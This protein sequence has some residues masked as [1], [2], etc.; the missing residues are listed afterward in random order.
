MDTSL[1]SD[2]PRWL[3]W[4]LPDNFS[5][6]NEYRTHLSKSGKYEGSSELE[7]VTLLTLGPASLLLTWGFVTW[8]L[9]GLQSIT[10]RIDK[11]YGG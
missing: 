10:L 4:S 3:W 8:N 11:R 2:R 7:I 9:G 6:Y 5:S 1:S